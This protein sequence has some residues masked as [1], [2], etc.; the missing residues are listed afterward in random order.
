VKDLEGRLVKP[1]DPAKDL[2]PLTRPRA[3]RIATRVD[4]ARDALERFSYHYLR[5]DPDATWWLDAP[6]KSLA[7]ALDSYRDKL[8]R[9]IA[10]KRG[11]DDE[12]MVGEPIGHDRLLAA[13]QRERV[14]YSPEEIV[15]IGEDQLAFCDAEMLKAAHELKCDTIEQALEIVKSHQAKPGAQDDTIEQIANESIAFLDSHDLVT[16]PDLC[17]ETWRVDMIVNYAADDQSLEDRTARMRDNNVHFTRNVTPHELIPGHHLQGFMGARYRPYR[18]IFSTPFLGEGW[19][20]YFEYRYLDL[21][22]AKSPE[23][24]LGIL[25]WR[26]HRAARIVVSLKY[27]LGTMQPDEMVKFLEDRVG[28]GE[29]AAKG[30]V[31]RFLEGGYGP[32]YQCAYMIGGLQLYALHDEIVKS[33]R[34]TERAFHDAVLHENA[35][36]IELIRA[37][38]LNL[39][40]ERD[41]K[42]SWHFMP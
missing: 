35:I 40:L 16:I 8:R 12:P 14:A 28:W 5:Y 36:P 38:L 2:P 20:L 29:G 41:A 27:H 21:G 13:L 30:E 39:P 22:W 10:G 7:S 9:E 33:G 3:L 18:R 19:C 26:R 15:K 17:R 4:D 24:K 42:A 23:D 6:I 31:R 34:M 32:L 11:G 1:G 37:R 25:F